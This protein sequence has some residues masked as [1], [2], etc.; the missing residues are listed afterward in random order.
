MI[1]SKGAADQWVIL[2]QA[3][4]ETGLLRMTRVVIYNLRQG[5]P[6]RGDFSTPAEPDGGSRLK[7]GNDASFY[8]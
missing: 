8:I 7:G 2:P 4:F 1:Y 3:S 5:E 6:P